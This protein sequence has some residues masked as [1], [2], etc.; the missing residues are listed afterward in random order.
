M[1]VV[2]GGSGFI[3]RHL[4]KMLDSPKVVDI[5]GENVIRRSV[6]DSFDDIL[7]DS[8]TIYHLAAIP[9]V[10]YSV[11]HPKVVAKT[12]IEGT[13]NLLEAVRKNDVETFMFTSSSSV[14]GDAPLPTKENTP[15]F[16]RSPYAASKLAG[17]EYCRI[18]NE[19]YGIRTL[20][21]RPFTVYGPG[22]RDDLA[23]TIFVKRML[24]GKNPVVFGNGLQRRDF[25]YVEDVARGMIEVVKGGKGG[26][27]YNLGAGRSRSVLEM[28]EKLN[29][30]LGTDIEPV[31]ES[32]REGDVLHTQADNS[33]MRK[34]GWTPQVTFEDGLRLTAEAIKASL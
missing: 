11:T 21:V 7:K 25:T 8:S 17:E 18:Y 12:N 15:K 27:A 13:L 24:E 32:V 23:I 16:P 10:R 2:T 29:Q 14:Y 28:I 4:V 9:G 30:I 19:L 34:L 26:Q 3:G 33:K 6:L 1:D 5:S 20:I 22:M 31:F